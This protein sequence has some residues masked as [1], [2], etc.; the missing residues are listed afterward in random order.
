M[1]AALLGHRPRAAPEGDL[2][3]APATLVLTRSKPGSAPLSAA[4]MPTTTWTPRWRTTW[5]A[6][7]GEHEARDERRGSRRRAR[8]ALGGLEQ[9][10]EATRDGRPLAALETFAQDA[11]FALRLIRRAPGFAAVTVLTVALGIGVNTAIFS[12]VHGVLLRPLPYAEP[13]RLV[14]AYLVNPAQEIT[15]GRLSV[16]EVADWRERSRVRSPRSAAPSASR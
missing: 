6:N 4:G 14:R 9:T 15:D 7:G 3:H 2:T 5:P 11:R 1:G 13:D 12:I 10:K 16:P 8:I